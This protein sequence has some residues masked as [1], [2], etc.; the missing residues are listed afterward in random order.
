MSS[1]IP[2]VTQ[3]QQQPSSG[4][5]G[6]SAGATL[7]GIAPTEDTFLTLLV[8]QL[9]NQNPLNP[10]DSTQFVSELAQFSQLEQTMTINQ[11]VGTLTQ[12]FA[13]SATTPPS[14]SGSNTSGSGS[15]TSK[16]ASA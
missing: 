10:T 14:G 6:N 12:K 16:P 3:T 7:G 8:A 5:N 13:P 2:P 15:N 1:S 4:A 11:N 9:K